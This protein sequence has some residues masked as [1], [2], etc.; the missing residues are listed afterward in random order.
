MLGFLSAISECIEAGWRA[1]RRAE[2]SVVDRPSHNSR[3]FRETPNHEDPPRHI[4]SQQR[5]FVLI[6]LV[7]QRVVAQGAVETGPGRAYGA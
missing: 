7:G 5:F 4:D 1:C 6:A 3:A 2:H